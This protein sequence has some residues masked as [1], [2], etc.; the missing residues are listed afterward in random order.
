MPCPPEPKEYR[1][2]TPDTIY[3]HGLKLQ[4]II[5]CLPHEKE[6]PQTLII[7]VELVKDLQK[8]AKTDDIKQTINYA[9]VIEKIQYFIHSSRFEL[10]E[11]LAEHIAQLLLK[12]YP[13]D[14]VTIKIQKPEAIAN[15]PQVGIIITRMSR[16]I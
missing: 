11:S 15:V 8:A 9:D 6:K 10:I 4:T 1:S 5:G 7:D 14:Q 13:S 2:M 12:E 3:I 16:S